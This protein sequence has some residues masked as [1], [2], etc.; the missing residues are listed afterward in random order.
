MIDRIIT[1]ISIF[2]ALVIV[3]PIHEFAH[4]FAAVKQGDF[5]PKMYKRYTLNP[6]AH[7]DM[8]GLACFIFAGF[9]WAKPMPVNPNNFK[10][11][12]RGCFFVAIAGVVANF[13]L[14]FL[15][16]PILILF[17]DYLL[18]VINFDFGLFDDVILLSLY[19]IFHMSLVFIVFNL[20]PFYPLDGFRAVDVFVKNK[21]NSFYRTLKNYGV[22]F[23]YLL[24]GLSFIADITNYKGLDLLGNFL[25]GAVKLIQY[26]ITA[27]WGL[28]F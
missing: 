18:P 23:I 26:P 8:I 19:Y 5:T 27:F 3:L 9:G 7:F 14:A 11:Y 4:G 1:Y 12:K 24:V 16:Y 6:F 22:Y 17:V 2:V 28:F 25:N 21:N 10:N 13:L 15:V 20:L